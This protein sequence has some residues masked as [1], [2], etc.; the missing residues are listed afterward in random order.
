M[1]A[2]RSDEV[3]DAAV[4]AGIDLG[5]TLRLQR[6][7]RAAFVWRTVR[8]SLERSHDLS[9]RQPLQA[10]PAIAAGHI[11]AVNHSAATPQGVMKPCR[12]PGRWRIRQWLTH[13]TGDAGNQADHRPRVTWARTGAANGNECCTTPQ[14]EGWREIAASPPG[15]A[16]PAKRQQPQPPLG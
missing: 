1:L 13:G 15:I 12:K 4:A 16:A 11:A 7:C 6:T 5:P 10:Q 9:T 8:V 2:A 14:A 3:A